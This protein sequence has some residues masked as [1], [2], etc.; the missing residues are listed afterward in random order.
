LTVGLFV[1]AP[2]IATNIFKAPDLAMVLR[3]ASGILLLNSLNEMQIGTL[4]GLE[5]FSKIARI[6]FVRAV[7]SPPLLIGGIW[8]GGLLGLVAGMGVLSLL[9]WILTSRMLNCSLADAGIV[10]RYNR[11]SS[12]KQILLHFV[13]PLVASGMLPAIVFWIARAIMAQYPEGYTQLGIF[14]AAEQWLVVQAFIPGQISNVSQPILSNI[15]ATGDQV[16]FRKTIITT[17]LLPVGIAL[18]LALLLI[19]LA[20]PLSILYGDTFSGLSPVIVLVCLV[21]VLRVFGGAFGTLLVT[22]NRM[23]ISFGINILW[24]ITLIIF[25]IFLANQGALGLAYAN[26]IAY[27]LLALLGVGILYWYGIHHWRQQ[28]SVNNIADS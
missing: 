27:S 5:H 1:F 16:R 15:Y 8:L 26:M 2:L 24:G 18:I 7:F 28:A 11:I 22:I 9:V 13:I 17:V 20:N 6:N 10:V 14:T 19:A 25:A 21:G 23:W 4:S 12:E 3:I